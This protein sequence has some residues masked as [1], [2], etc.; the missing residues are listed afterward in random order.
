MKSSCVILNDCRKVEGNMTFFGW[1]VH[2]LVIFVVLAGVAC[3]GIFAGKKLADKK[4]EKSG[5]AE[6]EEIK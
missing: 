1:F 3:L 4:N 5:S 2:Y 6:T